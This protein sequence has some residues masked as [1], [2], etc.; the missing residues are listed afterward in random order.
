MNRHLAQ[1]N[2]AHLRAPLDAPELADFVNNLDR[3]N[4]LAEA[5]DGFVWR[6]KTQEGDATALRPLG[7]D[8]LV[9][10]SL[11]RDVE[12]LRSFVYRTAHTDIMRRRAD[13]FVPMDKA[14]TVL[15]WVSAGHLPDMAE[16]LSRLERLQKSGP[17]QDAFG[18][19]Q[20]ATFS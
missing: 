14:Y 3:I 6:L 16:A 2:V 13:W 5:S 20:A 12:S 7:P 9:N 15:W 4:G 19:S 17:S 1:L 10:L 18:F 11:W 8:M